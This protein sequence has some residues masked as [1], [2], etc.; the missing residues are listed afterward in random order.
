MRLHIE[1]L[2]NE[3]N[4]ARASRSGLAPYPARSADLIVKSLVEAHSYKGH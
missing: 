3:Y 1:I 4:F 2:Y